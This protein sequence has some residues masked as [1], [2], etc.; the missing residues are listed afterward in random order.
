MSGSSPDKMP[1]NSINSD[2][3]IKS[4]PNLNN[5][6]KLSCTRNIWFWI[7]LSTCV[8]FIS[9]FYAHEHGRAQGQGSSD[10]LAKIKMYCESGSSGLGS[11]GGQG[12]K[13][14]DDVKIEAY[15]DLR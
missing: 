2:P 7:W 15:Y 10:L 6:N 1:S 8:L 11:T 4:N 13:A 12:D 5:N 14:E 3:D 9:V